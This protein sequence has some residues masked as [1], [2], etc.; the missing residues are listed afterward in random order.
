MPGVQSHDVDELGAEMA[1]L[2]RN[3]I[4]LLKLFFKILLKFILKNVFWSVAILLTF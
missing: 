3:S 4:G 2:E 1:T